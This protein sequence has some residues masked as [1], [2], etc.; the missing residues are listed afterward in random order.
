MT[1]D[2]DVAQ[3]VVVRRSI[4]LPRE[5]VFAAWLDPSSLARWMCPGTVVGATAEVDARVGGKFRI[6]MSHAHEQVEHTGEYLVIEPP[7]RL[8]F[9]WISVNTHHQPS[10]VTIEL[11]ARGASTDLT[12][13]HR[14]LPPAKSDAHRR[15]W[16]D[17]VRKLDET[18]SAPST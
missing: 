12:L 13:T 3:A 4:P 2:G 11:E 6:V 9:T 1:N 10:V 18:L 15:G 8:T 5:R 16:T 14:Q 17:I 7:S